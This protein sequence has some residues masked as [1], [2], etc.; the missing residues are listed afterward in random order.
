[1]VQIIAEVC[2]IATMSKPRIRGRNK[3]RINI[4]GQALYLTVHLPLKLVQESSEFGFKAHI[5]QSH[6]KAEV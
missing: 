4:E 5:F 1:M 6:L 3:I 2:G